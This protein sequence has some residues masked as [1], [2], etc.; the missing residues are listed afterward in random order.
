M[1][2]QKRKE[3]LRAGEDKMATYTLAY[4]TTLFLQELYT[5]WRT[6]CRYCPHKAIIVWGVV[7]QSCRTLNNDPPLEQDTSGGVGAILYLEN[8]RIEYKKNY[9]LNLERERDVGE[10][11]EW[12][13]V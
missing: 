9:R 7:A 12:K 6:Y 4:A 8:N 1:T 11:K 13:G 10:K 3:M 2:W 5:E